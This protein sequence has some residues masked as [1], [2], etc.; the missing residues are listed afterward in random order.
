VRLHWRVLPDDKTPSF[1]DI[2]LP[3]RRA[4]DTRERVA[5][6]VTPPGGTESAPPLPDT[7][8]T[9]LKWQ[10]AGKTLCSLQFHEFAAPTQRGRFRITIRPTA[11]GD[12]PTPLAPAGTWTIALRN[13]AFAPGEAI[14]AWVHRDESLYGYPRRGRQSYFEHPDYVRFEAPSGREK[15]T[16]DAGCPVKRARLLN[17]IATG[18]APIVVGGFQR[19]G[20]RAA[21]YSAGGPTTAPA[22]AGQPNRTAPNVMAVSDDSALDNGVLAAGSRSGSVVAM[23]GTSVAAPQIAREIIARL[24]RRQPADQAALAQ[25]AAAQEQVRPPGSLPPPERAGAGRLE[26]E[27]IVKLPRHEK[28]TAGGA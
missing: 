23:N 3:P 18:K 14:Q 20:G 12:T 4:G 22:G 21:K 25:L 24:A 7:R 19:K 10:P 15:E 6:T 16:D 13:R 26:L 5:A 17:A 28:A 27:P 1:L 8:N 2:W 9:V 11:A